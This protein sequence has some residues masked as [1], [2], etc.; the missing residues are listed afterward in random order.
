MS[1]STMSESRSE[2][3]EH[4]SK[5]VLY[6]LAIL[7]SGLKS[8]PRGARESRSL[9]FETRSSMVAIQ[10]RCHGS[11]CRRNLALALLAAVFP[12][13]GAREAGPE[14]ASLGIALASTML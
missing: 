3:L 8:G 1:Y 5:M 7:V 12:V 9:I 10:T 11:K 13:T 2:S 14:L 6:V 4:V